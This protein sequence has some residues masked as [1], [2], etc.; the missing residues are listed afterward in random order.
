MPFGPVVFGVLLAA[1]VAIGVVALW[2][3]SDTR[4]PV[5]MRL[6][7]YGVSTEAAL[8]SDAS[9]TAASRRQWTGVTRLLYGFGFGPGLAA[10]LTRAGLRLT[11]AEFALIT[12]SAGVLGFAIGAV[13][14]GGLVAGIAGA[15]LGLAVPIVYLRFK[16]GSRRRKFTEQLPDVLTLMVGGLRAGYGLPQTLEMMVARLPPPASEEFGWAVRAGTLG[17]PASRALNEMADRAGS[18]DLDL[19]VTAINVQA[20]LGGNL[21]QTLETIGATVRERLRIFREI[22]AM[23]AQ[24]RLTG[25]ILALTPLG[26]GIFMFITRPEYIKQMFVGMWLVLPIGAVIL[27]VIGFVVIQKIVAIEV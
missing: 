26:L 16:E 6:Q 5:D 17:M 21:A 1:S 13:R 24:Q 27:Q 2:R 3:L 8:P 19:I 7:E 18:G 15:I 25:Y 4:D 10:A 22:R 14:V 23:T 11:A 20:E 9:A 12:A